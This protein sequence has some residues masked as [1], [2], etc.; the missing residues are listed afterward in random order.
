M[1]IFFAKA[2]NDYRLDGIDGLTSTLLGKVRGCM[3]SKST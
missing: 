3:R 1:G 2:K